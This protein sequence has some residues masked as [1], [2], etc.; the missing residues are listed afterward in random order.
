MKR[1]DRY[2]EGMRGPK[3]L[4]AAYVEAH[5]LGVRT[6]NFDRLAEL[7]LPT[8]SMRFHGSDAG[9]FGNAEAILDAFYERPP[10]DELVVNSIHGTGDR[11]AEA[12]YAWANAPGQSAGRLRITAQRGLVSTIRIEEFT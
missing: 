7:L 3:E 2:A 1:A 10:D 11:L 12:T 8:A 9:P 4:L 6:G 5:N